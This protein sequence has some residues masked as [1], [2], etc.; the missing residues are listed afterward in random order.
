ML[1][2]A[3]RQHELTIGILMSPPSWTSFPPTPSHS[4]R[5]SQGTGLS[6]LHQ[7]ADS[8]WPSILHMVIYVMDVTYRVCF[9]VALSLHPS[10]SSPCCVRESVFYVC[11]SAAALQIGSSVPLPKSKV[12]CSRTGCGCHVRFFCDPM[13]TVARQVPLSMGSPR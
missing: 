5:L 2:S 10:V 1:V 4:P 6:S 11:V 7:A 8:H 3:I 9:N 12:L 13:N